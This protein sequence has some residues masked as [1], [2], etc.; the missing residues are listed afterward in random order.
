MLQALEVGKPVLVPRT[1]LVGWRAEKYGLGKTYQHRDEQDL[2]RAWKEFRQE[3]VDGYES[4]VKEY[5]KRKEPNH[6]YSNIDKQRA[7]H[8]PQSRTGYSSSSQWGSG[9]FHCPR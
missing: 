3:P 5:A 4:R 1:G 9:L 7:A 8:N 2:A 6:R